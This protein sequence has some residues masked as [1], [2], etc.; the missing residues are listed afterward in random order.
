MTSTE[1][2][3]DRTYRQCGHCLKSALDLDSDVFKQCSACKRAR[4]LPFEHTLLKLA[5]LA[6]LELTPP[7]CLQ[8]NDTA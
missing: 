8:F 2:L 4:T 1:R 5:A 6:D 7:S 3:D